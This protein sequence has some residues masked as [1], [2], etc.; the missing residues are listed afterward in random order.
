V[1]NQGTKLWACRANT[2]QLIIIAIAAIAVYVSTLFSSF[3]SDDAYQILDNPWIRESRFIP[4]IF[5]HSVWGFYNAGL[6]LPYYRPMMHLIYMFNYNIFGASPWG[7][8]LISIL[9]NAGVSVLVFL[10]AKH[11]LTGS[12]STGTGW[13]SPA[14]IAA[15]LFATHPVHT[16]AVAWIS[17]L[18]ELTFAFFCLLSFYLYVRF[19]S[20]FK[21]SYSLSLIAF[22]MALLSKET[23]LILPIIIIAHDYF[24]RKEGSGSARKHLKIYVPYL[25]IAGLY[26]MGRSYAVRDVAA[27]KKVGALSAY[28]YVIN[29]L[30]FFLQ[31]MEKLIFP[32][33]LNAY[34]IFHPLSSIFEPRGLLALTAALAFVVFF[35]VALKMNKL[36]FWCLA[37]VIVPLLPTFYIIGN[38]EVGISERYLYLPSFGFVLLL[39]VLVDKIR[40]KKSKMTLG[41]GIILLLVIGSYSFATISRNSVWKDECTLWADTVKKSPDSAFVHRA[42]GSA[43]FNKGGIDEALTQFLLAAKLDPNNAETHM[44]LGAVYSRRGMIDQAVAHYRLSL[45]GD[46]FNWEAYYGLGDTYVN[47]G[48]LDDGIKLLERSLSLKTDFPD[49]HKDICCAFLLKGVLDEALKHCQIAVELTPDDA[50]ARYKLALAYKKNG[51]TYKAIDEYETALGLMPTAAAHNNLGELYDSVG[52]YDKAI[53]QYQAV[54]QQQPHFAVAYNNLGMIYLKMG[55]FDRAVENFTCAL[56]L[57][58]DNRGFRINLEKVREMR[59]HQCRPAH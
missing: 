17:A 55:L 23:A 27:A 44:C 35:V 9:F 49:A 57:S 38:A 36:V 2:S 26:F 48:R 43:L 5:S 15:V 33:H 34:H 6:P 4:T 59:L 39:A 24:L 45:L 31:Y 54:I 10:T 37:L 52:M 14:F 7:F 16:E 13:L 28:G 8:H 51:A 19:E 42:L 22:F 32:V 18:P 50:D 58:P 40:A 11:L 1:A 46:P 20:G 30:S 3:V 41:L 25:L 47:M 53:E 21:S 12:S 29:I 56:R